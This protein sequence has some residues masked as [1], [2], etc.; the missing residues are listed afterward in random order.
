M[1]ISIIQSD[2][3]WENKTENLNNFSRII[4]DIP[5]TDIVV[6]P[7]MFSTGFSM[8]PSPIAEDMDGDTVKWLKREA[9]RNEVVII[10]SLIISENNNYYNRLLVVKPDGDIQKYD[11]RHLFRMSGEHNEY[12]PGEGKL[13]V[14]IK[15]W[16]I[17]PLVCYDLRFPVWSRNVNNE[18]DLLIYVANWPASRVNVWDSLLMARALENQSYVV[19]VNRI[20]IDKDKTPFNGHSQIIDFKG[21]I[22]TKIEDKAEVQTISLSKDHLNTFRE[23][24]PAYMDAD[25]FSIDM[26]E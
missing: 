24:F 14:D 15:G 20:G 12:T 17:C 10:T 18:Y 2:L 8:E 19:A 4:R 13:I 6:L 9:E 26:G 5:Q 16:K 21:K 3:V 11:K 7:E 25:S 23:K 22:L 1:E